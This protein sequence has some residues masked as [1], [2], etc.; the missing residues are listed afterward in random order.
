MLSKH[1]HCEIPTNNRYEI[2]LESEGSIYSTKGRESI[3]KK[4]QQESDSA[5][6]KSAFLLVTQMAHAGTTSVTV[7]NLLCK[8]RLLFLE[9]AKI[10]KTGTDR[11]TTTKENKYLPVSYK[12][13]TGTKTTRG[14]VVIRADT[15]VCVYI[16]T[17]E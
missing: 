13:K 5:F 11:K 14:F 12:Q 6:L 10:A 8:S 4:P 15:G 3:I 7:E 16:C 17:G 1:F 9:E 2:S